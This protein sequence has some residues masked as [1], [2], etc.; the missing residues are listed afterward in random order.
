MNPWLTAAL[1]LR[2]VENVGVEVAA[3]A[4]SVV[5]KTADFCVR[6]A[7]CQLVREVTDEQCRLLADAVREL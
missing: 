6:R 2:A 5:H 4:L 3:T 1:T 7:V